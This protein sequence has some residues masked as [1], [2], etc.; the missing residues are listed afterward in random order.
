MVLR[1]PLEF[2]AGVGLAALLFA[3]VFSWSY[4][5]RDASPPARVS[6]PSAPTSPD[7][8]QLLTIY[9]V[10]GSPGCLAPDQLEAQVRSL[11]RASHVSASLARAQIAAF[12]DRGVP[13][14]KWVRFS[15]HPNEFNAWQGPPDH[16]ANPQG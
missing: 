8:K 5:S 4:L 14:L 12:I 1:K 10:Y 2:M 11:E 16:C 7:A 13:P 15:S 6:P 9:Y 3:L